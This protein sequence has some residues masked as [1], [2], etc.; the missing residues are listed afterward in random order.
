MYTQAK[1]GKKE[2]VI[3]KNGNKI[4]NISANFKLNL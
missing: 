3:K 1:S 4:I 2:P